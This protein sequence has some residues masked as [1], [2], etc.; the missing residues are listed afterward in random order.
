LL[1]TEVSN[2]GR[3]GSVVIDADGRVVEFRE[4]SKAQGAAS[5]NA[6]IYFLGRE[7]LAA[8]PPD[9]FVSLEYEVFPKLVGQG[10]SGFATRG[11]FLDIGTPEDFALAEAFF[12]AMHRS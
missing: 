4:K 9:G 7:V 10:L 5:I 11:R 8:I 1:L 6:G 12:A 2:S 3:Y